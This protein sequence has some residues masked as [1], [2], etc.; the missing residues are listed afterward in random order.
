[1]LEI[2][3]SELLLIMIIGLIVLGPERFPIAIKT[4]INWIRALFS[5]AA[6]VQHE[7]L[8]ELKLQE[9]QERLKKIEEKTQLQTLSEEFEQS[10]KE[11]K[12]FSKTLKK[13]YQSSNDSIN[14]ELSKIKVFTGDLDVNIPEIVDKKKFIIDNK[15]QESSI[16]VNKFVTTT[17][18]NFAK[19]KDSLEYEY[20]TKNKIKNNFDKIN[21]E[22]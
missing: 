4:S 3:F 14:A 10:M 18:L 20:T 22:N 19:S 12:K 9:L 5:L 16:I 11:L 21:G 2:S 1:M 6:N 8:Q 15:Q 13:N 17:S 7:L